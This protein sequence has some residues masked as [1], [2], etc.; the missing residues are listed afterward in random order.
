MCVCIY[1]YIY[2]YIKHFKNLR[3]RKLLKV[4]D[5]KIELKKCVLMQSEVI[6]SGFEINKAGIFPV[7][8]KIY[9]I[10]GAKEPILLNYYDS[11]YITK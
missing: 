11:F 10:K 2:I 5:L 7:N 4:N 6:Y 9:D 8:K 1:I 3:C